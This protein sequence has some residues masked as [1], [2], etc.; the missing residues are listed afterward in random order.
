MDSSLCV[1][2]NWIALDVITRLVRIT[3]STYELDDQGNR[4]DLAFTE[5]LLCLLS[6]EVDFDFP[7]GQEYPFQCTV[8]N[9]QHVK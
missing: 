7:L 1:N 6:S 5:T 9:Q 4:G 2:P 8:E 3:A